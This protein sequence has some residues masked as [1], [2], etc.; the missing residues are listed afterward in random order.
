MP[1]LTSGFEVRLRDGDREHVVHVAGGRVAICGSQADSRLPAATLV[2]AP[3]KAADAVRAALALRLKIDPARVRIVSTRP[4]RSNADPCSTARSKP[5]GAA[6]VVEAKAQSRTFRYY[7][8]AAV[9]VSC[10][11]PA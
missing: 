8:D 2:S 4:A 9:T 7:T 10:E 3:L 1:V 6:F 5:S 11:P